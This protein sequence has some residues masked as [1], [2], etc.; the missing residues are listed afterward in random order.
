LPPDQVV[1]QRPTSS[2]VQKELPMH[3]LNECASHLSPVALRF[4]EY[5][6]ADPERL[7]R[8]DHLAGD[9][10][11]WL[12]IASGRFYPLQSWPTFAG[13]EKLAEVQRATVD[14]TRLVKAIPERIFDNDVRRMAAFYGFRNEGLLRLILEPP[15][16]LAGALLRNDFVDAED[17]FWWLEA[18]AGQIGG[19]QLRYFERFYRTHPVI[20]RF[21][22]E[23]E[24]QPYYRDPLEMALRHVIADNLGQPIAAEGVLNTAIAVGETRSSSVADRAALSQMYRN[25]LEESGSGLAGDLTLCS[26]DDVSLRQNRLWHGGARGPIHAIVEMTP[27]PP[28][29]A[30]F[31]AFKAGR[32]SLYNSP[33]GALI[34][35]KR[36][37]AILSEHADSALFT[38]A[39][40][41]LLHRHLPWT[42]T[43]GPGMATFNGVTLPLAELLLA[44]R[45]DFVIK[46]HDGAGGDRVTLGRSVPAETWERLVATAMR[47]RGWLAQERVDSRPYLYQHGEH[48]CAVHAAVWGTFCF[49]DAFGGGFLR[50]GPAGAGDGVINSARGAE[51]SVLF[52][53]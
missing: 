27:Q 31:R 22:A 18:N 40:R 47:E 41:A 51:E 21:L 20:A 7:R 44:H 15:N 49:G 38:A 42:R 46:P 53:V 50:V 48:G 12:R 26:Y 45:E 43:I 39:E 10:P 8:L 24:I 35:D 17:G 33:V 19:W 30:V 37:L 29:E 6:S 13:A 25:L 32:L 36:N 1:E 5:V 34:G 28:P 4:L 2:S 52:E 23:Q 11:E 16:G 14:L 3:S 9:Y